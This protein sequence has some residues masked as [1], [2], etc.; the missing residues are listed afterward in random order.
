MKITVNQKDYQ[1]NCIKE[2]EQ[3]ILELAKKIDQKIIALKNNL[4][5]DNENLLVLLCLM[6]E[7]EIESLIEDKEKIYNNISNNFEQ[8]NEIIKTVTS[9]IK[10]S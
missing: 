7:G 10:N 9:R 6:S 1:I 4:K 8:A 3:K 5:L 2:E